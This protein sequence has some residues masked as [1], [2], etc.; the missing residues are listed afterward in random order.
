MIGRLEV[1]GFGFTFTIGSL[2]DEDGDVDE[3]VT[4]KYNF[5]QIASRDYFVSR[6]SYNVSEV[7]YQWFGTSG[8]RVKVVDESSHLYARVLVKT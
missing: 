5:A 6:K 1:N 8:F 4:S 7:S 3:N 2:R